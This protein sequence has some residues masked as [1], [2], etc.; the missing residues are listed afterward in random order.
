MGPPGKKQVGVIGEPV[1]LAAFLCSQ[2][3]A[4]TLLVDV[5]SFSRAGAQPPTVAVSR[6]RSKK[7]HQ[8]I[9]TF[10]L[11]F[12]RRVGG[13]RWRAMRDRLPAVDLRWG[14]PPFEIA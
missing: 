10:R 11:D 4:G 6:L 13:R 3:P 12:G 5:D 8:R 7:R 2:A 1:N 14:W 9:R